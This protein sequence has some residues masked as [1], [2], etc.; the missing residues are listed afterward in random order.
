MNFFMPW[1]QRCFLNTFGV[2]CVKYGRF[3]E[4]NTILCTFVPSG[5]LAG[6][7]GES[8]LPL[9]GETPWDR[10]QWDCL[11][12]KQY[13]Y[14][15]SRFYMDKIKPVCNSLFASAVILK[16]RIIYGSISRLYSIVI[17]NA[18][19]M[20]SAYRTGMFYDGGEV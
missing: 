14:P 10:K 2:A 13:Q 19:C 1:L 12:G 20:A 18:I 16:A 6:S 9:L 3:A 8:L 11:L 5:G 15:F 4:L 17:I 7:Y